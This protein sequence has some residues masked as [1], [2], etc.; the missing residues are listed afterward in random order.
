[1]SSTPYVESD[2]KS[3]GNNSGR[4]QTLF[5]LVTGLSALLASAPKTV[6]LIIPDQPET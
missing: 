6:V 1:M 4:I 5:Y 2:A 3:V